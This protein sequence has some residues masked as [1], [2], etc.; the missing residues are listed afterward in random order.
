MAQ[1]KQGR[2]NTPGKKAE[3]QGQ[4]WGRVS[5]AGQR[6]SARGCV[7]HLTES[8]QWWS[9]A[10]TVISI[11][12]MS[13]LRPGRL[14]KWYRLGESCGWN[15]D[16][17]TQEPESL[18]T[19]HSLTQAHGP[20]RPVMRIPLAL[21]CLPP[22]Y[23]LKH[24]VELIHG[25]RRGTCVG[26][27][28]GAA[29]QPTGLARPCGDSQTQLAVLLK[30]I[31]LDTSA[32]NVCLAGAGEVFSFFINVSA[33]RSISSP[34]SAGPAEHILVA[35]SLSPHLNLSPP[36]SPPPWDSTLPLCPPNQDRGLP[37]GLCLNPERGARK[38]LL[39]VFSRLLP[40]HP[41]SLSSFVTS[42]DRPSLTALPQVTTLSY[43]FDHHPAYFLHSSYPS[44]NYI[45]SYLSDK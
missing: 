31:G 22:L 10:C 38:F 2:H 41:S 18:T 35:S 8:S 21:T 9:G 20:V 4:A 32:A 34:W 43:F 24:Q 25:S 30:T 42:S 36:S 6:V 1:A 17:L 16:R 15:P 45:V 5:S 23:S 13:K 7:G 44:G 14:R 29:K 40:S 3:A 37:A 27:N 19:F 39:Q 26:R 28:R 33:S 12:Q 11:L